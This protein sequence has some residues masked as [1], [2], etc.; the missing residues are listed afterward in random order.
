MNIEIRSKKK[1]GRA[2]LH[3]TIRCRDTGVSHFNL[4]MQVDI[5]KW[6]E[7]SKTERKKANFLDSMN[8]TQ[9]IQEIENGLKVLR[10]YHKCTKEEV[11]KLIENVV[12]HDVREEMIKKEEAKSKMESEK[13]KRVKEFFQNYIK[14]M[15]CGVRRTIKNKLYSKN[16]ISHWEQTV[17]KVLDFHKKYPFSW[18]DIN[19]QLISRFVKY[20]EDD[21]LNKTT[22]QKLMKDFKKLIKD[23]ES[24]G[25][26]ENFRARNLNY[27]IEVRESDK[28]TEVYLT[29]EELQGL[30]DMELSGTEEQVRDVFLIGCFLG[31][32]VSDYGRIEP[33]WFGTTRNGVKV[34]RLEQTKT[35]S[36]VCVPIVGR[37]LETLLKKYDYCVPKISDQEIDRA[38]KD[39][40]ER[41][42]LS[43][44][45]LTIKH[46]TILK[47]HEKIALYT[48]KD[49]GRKLFEINERGECIKTKWAMVASHT[50]RRTCITN[51]YLARKPDGSSKY[52]LAEMMHVSG[53]KTESQFRAYIKC[54][55]DEF[56]EMVAAANDKDGDNLF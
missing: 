47:K 49:G 33:E 6:I 34:I 16:T 21:D 46:K 8:Y 18:D 9:K 55:L 51:M 50:A 35:G 3:S 54:S 32:R 30:Y 11:N 22:I 7:C 36:K 13:R 40:C 42:S 52:T 56:A 12:L 48:N 25:I 19:Q 43:I 45:S 20:L 2:Y 17:K 28:S 37:Q 10:R 44:P 31:Q 23:A 39:I 14:E 26:H 24:E 41:L 29:T 1:E 4:L 38:I 5:K 15:E 27:T 53:H